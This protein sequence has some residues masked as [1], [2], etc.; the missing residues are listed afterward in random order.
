MRRVLH[1]DL[2]CFYAAVHMRDDPSLAGRPVVVGGDPEGRGV[3]AA[4]SYEA[5]RYGIRSAMSAAEARRRCPH[6]VF[7]RPDFPRYRRD[8][9]EIF[10]L[11][12]ELT[13][14]VQAVS[15]DEAYLDV[16]DHLAPWG[17]AT[18]IAREIRRRVRAERGLTVSVGVAPNKLVAKIASDQNKPDGLTVVRPEE[19]EAFLAPLPV[20]RLHGVGPATERVLAEMGAATIAD[21]RALPLDR[22]TARFG[23]HGQAL[24]DYAWGRDERPVVTS[25]E[26]KS[27]GT[28]NTYR[29]DLTVLGE[30]EA[31]VERMAAEVAESLERRDLAGRTVTLKV[32]YDDFTTVTRSR[33]LLAPTCAAGSIGRCAR[34]LLV[35]RTEAATR[36][37]RLLGVTASNLVN[38]GEGQLVLFEE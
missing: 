33:T 22:L 7:L 21:L 5:R 24:H 32:R 6:A 34:E 17:S 2:D 29:T 11:Y 16:T 26:R 37:V 31:E 27:L 14:L 8:S 1:A 35:E 28:E 13:P 18:A 9:Q 10:A 25:S 36:P 19:V 20:R 38:G 30:M 23:R 4:C 3:V 15:I 12:G